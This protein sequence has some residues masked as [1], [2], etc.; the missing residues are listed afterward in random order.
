MV[1]QAMPASRRAACI[2]ARIVRA[3]WRDQKRQDARCVGP[4]DGPQ[5]MFFF[6]SNRVGCIGSILISAIVTVV[7]LLLFRVI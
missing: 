3:V 1:V 6:F 2:R 4:L 7:L 5:R